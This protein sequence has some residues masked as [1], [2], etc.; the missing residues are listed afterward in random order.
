MSRRCRPRLLHAVELISIEIVSHTRD[1]HLDVPTAAQLPFT[2][3]IRY[4]YPRSALN[5]F[6]HPKMTQIGSLLRQQDAGSRR[7]EGDEQGIGCP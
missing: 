6:T 4:P 2:S 3:R 7:I 1:L 5:E